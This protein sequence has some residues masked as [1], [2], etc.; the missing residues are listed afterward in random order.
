MQI[1]DKNASSQTQTMQQAGKEHRLWI[2]SYLVLAL[3]SI[4][5]YFMVQLS[6]SYK[7]GDH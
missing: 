3:A 7:D 5:F 1:E 2:E 4:S 6:S